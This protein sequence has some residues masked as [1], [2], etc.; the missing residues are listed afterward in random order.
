M[1]ELIAAHFSN[2]ELDARIGDEASYELPTDEVCCVLPTLSE[3]ADKLVT[4][5]CMSFS[6]PHDNEQTRRSQFE[7]GTLK[8]PR[9][10]AAENAPRHKGAYQRER[11]EVE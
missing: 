5:L 1:D 10:R 3:T 4:H 6:S 8:R 7:P 11:D 2:R 9:S